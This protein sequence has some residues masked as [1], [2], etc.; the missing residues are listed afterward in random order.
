MLLLQ[1]EKNPNVCLITAESRS[2]V[3]TARHLLH[4]TFVLSLQS[5]V[6]FL[7]SG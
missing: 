4:E 1:P 3:S 7:G 6:R 5:Q 2:N